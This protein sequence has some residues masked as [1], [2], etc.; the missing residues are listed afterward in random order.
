MT[1]SNACGTESNVY[2]QPETVKIRKMNNKTEAP[3]AQLS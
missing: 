3:K 2:Q 1:L